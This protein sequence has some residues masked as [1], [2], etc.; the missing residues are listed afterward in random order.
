MADE[1]TGEV[2]RRPGR[3]RK[4]EAVV[5]NSSEPVV[6]ERIAQLQKQVQELTRA[7]VEQTNRP[8]AEQPRKTPE[9]TQ[10][11]IDSRAEDSV[12]FISPYRNFRIVSE[13]IF[14][15]GDDNKKHPRVYEFHSNRAVGIYMT[16]DKEEIEDLRWLKAQRAYRDHFMESDTAPTEEQMIVG[17][18]PRKSGIVAQIARLG[19]PEPADVTKIRKEATQKA[20]ALK[21]THQGTIA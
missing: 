13:K 12:M 14:T 19:D 4:Q 1:I 6:D 7:L 20:I 11:D 21:E 16:R 17:R 5:P 15:L 2:K 18:G 10:E 3:P 8:I 9:V